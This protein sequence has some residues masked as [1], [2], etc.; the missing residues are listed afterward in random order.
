MGD[1]RVLNRVEDLYQAIQTEEGLS[2]PP[3]EEN[4]KR[5]LLQPPLK[6]SDVAREEFPDF[7]VEER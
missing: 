1:R 4:L 5:L 6:G 3:T 7:N 2:M